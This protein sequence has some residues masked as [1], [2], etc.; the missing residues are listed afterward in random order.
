MEKKEKIII[1][2]YSAIDDINELFSEEKKLDKSPT[3]ILF[4]KSGKL[5]S[6]GIVNLIVAIEEKIE[7]N[8][9]TS[10]SLI[11]G[12]N[13]SQKNNYFKTIGSLADYINNTLREN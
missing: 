3:T 7:E 11:E 1:T 8:F 10:I 13:N 9:N 4:D 5:D 2:I 12:I 6:L